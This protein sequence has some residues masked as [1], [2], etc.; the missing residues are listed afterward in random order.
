MSPRSSVTVGYSCS[1][2][3]GVRGGRQGRAGRRSGRPA[4]PRGEVDGAPGRRRMPGERARGC[5]R[6]RP[7]R[8]WSRLSRMTQ[9]RWPS[10]VATARSVSSRSAAVG[11]SRVDLGQRAIGPR[12]APSGRPAR[13]RRSAA[14]RSGR[15]VVD[16]LRAAPGPPVAVGHRRDRRAR[17]GGA[18]SATARRRAARAP[19]SDRARRRCPMPY[20]WARSSTVIQSPASRAPR[21]RSCQVR[22]GSSVEG[23]LEQAEGEPARLEVRLAEQ[24]VGEEQQRRRPSRRVASRKPRMT[25]AISGQRTPWT[26]PMPGATT[27]L[28]LEVLRVGELR[29][30]PALQGGGEGVG[31]AGCS[32]ARLVPRASAASGLC[33]ATNATARAV[34][35]AAWSVGGAR[36]RSGHDRPRPSA[37]GVARGVI[38]DGRPDGSRSVL[39]ARACVPRRRPR[40][41]PSRSRAPRPSRRRR[42]G[43]RCRRSAAAS[44]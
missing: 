35:R 33:S 15:R 17:R 4:R 44:G 10:S 5:R 19:P 23:A 42:S 28:A 25:A 43:R 14:P 9:A 40:R 12:R 2:S 30:R 31:V 8:A 11:R 37:V 7:G 26:A 20:G 6:R 39:A 27:L 18:P 21:R 32:S 1:G 13:R 36:R 3:A 22:S 41:R 16:D 34:R 24:P 38:V 29:S